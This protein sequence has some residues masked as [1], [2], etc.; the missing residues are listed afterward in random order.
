MRSWQCCVSAALTVI[1]LLKRD[2][3]KNFRPRPGG[4][5]SVGSPA[6]AAGARLGCAP[7]RSKPSAPDERSLE[8]AEVFQWGPTRV[9]TG[10]NAISFDG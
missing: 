7:N 8:F 2:R 6:L 3:G 4:K 10:Q 9:L 1:V 5:Y